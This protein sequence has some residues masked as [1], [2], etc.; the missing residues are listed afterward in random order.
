[1]F[2]MLVRVA[3]M[4]AMLVR[5]AFMNATRVDACCMHVLSENYIKEMLYSTHLSDI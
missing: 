2:P 3:F 4:N 5:V 1:M